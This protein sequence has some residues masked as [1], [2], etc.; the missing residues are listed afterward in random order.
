MLTCVGVKC[1]KLAKC[2]R[3]GADRYFCCLNRLSNS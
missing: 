2:S 1:I 3:S